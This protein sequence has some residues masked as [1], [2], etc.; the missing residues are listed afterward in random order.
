MRWAK[1][2][3]RLWGDQKFRRLS[4]DG[5]MLFLYLLTTPYSNSIPGTYRAGEAMIAEELDWNLERFRKAYAELFKE[6]LA[7]GDFNGRLIWLP[8]AIRYNMP[9]NTNVIKGWRKSWD[10]LSECT[11]KKDVWASLHDALQVRGD[12]WVKAFTETC[13]EPFIKWSAEPTANP[14]GEQEQEQEQYQEQEQEYLSARSARSPKR[15][16]RRPES[17]IETAARKV[18][19]ELQLSGRDMQKF[20]EQ[21]IEDEHRRSTETPEA[22][23]EMMVRCRR[24]YE[25]VPHAGFVWPPKQFFAQGVWKQSKLWQERGRNESKAEERFERNVR[26]VQAI[27]AERSD[28]DPGP[29]LGDDAGDVPEHQSLGG[30]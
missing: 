30:G 9:D 3:R 29:A 24:S 8:H 21:V 6:G 23:A 11:L 13:P 25:A 28:E 4:G 14:T 19:D 5:K 17:A 1:V 16:R 20:V 27:V 10:E 7:I 12:Q 22:I 2:D 18:C 15:S 26:D